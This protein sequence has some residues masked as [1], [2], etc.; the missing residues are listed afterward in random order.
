MHTVFD[1]LGQVDHLSG[2]LAVDELGLKLVTQ[3]R[4]CLV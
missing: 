1:P 2:I 3:Q 4:H